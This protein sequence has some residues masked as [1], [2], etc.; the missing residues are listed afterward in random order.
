MHIDPKA[1]DWNLL[2][3]QF[4]ALVHDQDVRE[5]SIEMFF[6]GE[7]CRRIGDLIARAAEHKI[8]TNNVTWPAG[9][10]ASW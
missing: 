3:N 9:E 5:D 6:D 8:K 4:E 10:T 2:K 7:I 1:T